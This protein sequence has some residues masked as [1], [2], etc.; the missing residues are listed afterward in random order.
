MGFYG[1]ITNTNRT[2]FV[3]DKVYPSRSQMDDSV[4]TDGIYIG[5]YVLVEYGYN[6][7]YKRLYKLTENN[8]DK[9]YT[10]RTL[11]EDTR[12]K[13]SNVPTEDENF[14]VQNEIIF[15]LDKDL[16]QQFYTC[17]GADKDGYAQFELLAEPPADA[18]TYFDNYYEDVIKKGYPESRGYDSTVWQKVYFDGAEKYVMIAELNSVVPTFDLTIDAPT[19]KPA[20]PFFDKDSTSIYY[21]LH[22]QPQWGFK[23]KEASNKE[24]SDYTVNYEEVSFDHENQKHETIKHN[25]DGEIFYNKA[26]LTKETRNHIENL[27]DEIKILPTGSSEKE[28]YNTHNP[29]NPNEV[30]KANDIQELSII[31]PSIGNTI[32]DVWDVLYGKERNLDIDWDSYK[33]LRLVHKDN[34]FSYSTDEIETV[35]G[36]INSVHDLMGMIIVDD[37]TDIGIAD[38]D[39]IYYGNLGGKNLNGYYIKEK[40][41]KYTPFT[42]DELESYLKKTA[43]VQLTQFEANK[44]YTKNNNGFVLVTNSEYKEGTN[45]YSLV[46]TDIE[47]DGSYAKNKYFYL[48]ESTLNYVKDQNDSP[49]EN[50]QYYDIA[51]TPVTNGNDNLF[52][53]PTKHIENADGTFTGLFYENKTENKVYKIDGEDD[54]AFDPAGRYFIGENYTFEEK[55]D[56]NLEYVTVYTFKNEKPVNLTEFKYDVND[57]TGNYY[58]RDAAGDYICLTD[59]NAIDDKVIYGKLVLTTKKRFYE[60]NLYYYKSG[61]DF[62]FATGA[63]NIALSYVVLEGAEQA[64]KNTFYE[65]NKYYY[66]NNLGYDVLDVN[67]TMTANREYFLKYFAYVDNDSRGILEKGAEWNSNVTTIPEEVTLAKREENYI[68]KELVGFAKTLNTIHGLIIRINALLKFDDYLTRDTKTVQGCINKLND[69]INTFA[70]LLPGEM[71]IV[72]EY[73]RVASAPYETDSW[74]DLKINDDPVDH[75][76]TVNHEY[77]PVANTTSTKDINNNGNTIELYTPKVDEKGHVVGNNIETVTLPYSYKTIKVENSNSVAEAA[78]TIAASGQSADNTQ[79]IVN[80]NASNKWIKVDNN[81][82]DTIKFGHA[83][84][85]ATANQQFGLAADVDITN[86]D[87]DNTFEVPNFTL[88]EAGHVIDAQTHTI[89]IPESFTKINVQG[90][91]I[92]ETDSTSVSGTV[93]PDTLTDELIIS[94]GN[95][96]IELQANTTNDSISV[97]HYVKAFS[98]TNGEEVNYNTSGNTIEL[99]KLGYDKA[100]HVISEETTKYTL[101]N[102][103]QTLKIA[104]TGASSENTL[105]AVGG[106]LKASSVIDTVTFDV[107]NRWVQLIANGDAKSVKIAHA[108]PGGTL[109][110]AGD[111]ADLELTYGG[112]FNIPY[113]SY[114]KMG[115]ISSSNVRK[116]TM[117]ITPA[118]N[119]LVDYVPLVAG[120]NLLSATDTINNAFAKL[121][122]YVLNSSNSTEESLTELE[123]TIATNKQA[124]DQAIQANTNLIN[125]NKTETD[126]AIQTNTDLINTNQTNNEQAIS[127]INTAIQNEEKRAIEAEQA[128]QAAIPA[129]PSKPTTAG[130]YILHILDDGAAEWIAFDYTPPVV[131]EPTT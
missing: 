35:A 94:S 104:N 84:S 88:D 77:H 36:C 87:V 113:F 24:L 11:T 75:K 119:V 60:P 34:G 12:A 29:E 92:L 93:E 10:S 106:D 115:H 13:Y 50:I 52:Y 99:Q 63:F 54:P 76:I 20:K 42:D 127:Q 128:I 58:Y 43:P 32:S 15:I 9:F 14:V 47:L 130:Y 122:N 46:A 33:G 126:A 125:S 68:W 83:L 53:H 57:K 61:N 16:K 62:I 65:P 45:Y 5:R 81:T 100:G 59:I 27:A 86:L 78:Q 64:I 72:D 90:S 112:T 110:N 116:L 111:N 30:G 39:K 19:T 96:W 71:L 123:N 67:P 21:K 97:L 105:T 114:D 108:A 131:E 26:G 23:I 103:Y 38:T 118:K 109:A 98:K 120:N 4:H 79:D 66:K 51:L 7:D 82:E 56:E 2:Q 3:F 8:I 6:G 17:I 31:L 124:T 49:N 91:S 74:I 117:P 40:S 129:I 1:N 102:N 101:P 18:G 70:T 41:Y 48:D 25:Y 28:W 85:P 55:L 121:E 69:I 89:T 95:K 22:V 37:V 44:Y 80:F 107:G 73:G